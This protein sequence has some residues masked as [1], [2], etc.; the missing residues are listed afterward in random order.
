MLNLPKEEA[1]RMHAAYMVYTE[2][3]KK[4]VLVAN[5]ACSPLRSDHG[6]SARQQAKRRERAV[7]R[8]Q[9]ATRRLLP[10]RGAGSRLALSRAARCPLPTTK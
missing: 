9:G 2:A 7:R 4:G 6:A 3:M 8:D 5:H 10:H 1:G